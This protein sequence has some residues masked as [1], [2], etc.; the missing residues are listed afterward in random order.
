LLGV[1]R[2]AVS[3]VVTAYK[4]HGKTSSA[5]RNSGRK[6]KLSEKDRRTLKRIVSKNHRTTAAKVRQ[7]LDRQ[8]EDTDCIKTARRQPHKSNIHGTAAFVKHL[9]TEHTAK[10]R[11]RWCDDDKTWT[12]DEWNYSDTSA[13]EDNSFRNHIR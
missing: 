9:I 11:K 3:K 1:S 13:N 6:P 8:I 7:E 2:A 12:S 10:K 5:A 4:I